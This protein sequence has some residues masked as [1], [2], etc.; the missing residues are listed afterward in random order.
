MEHKEFAGTGFGGA[1]YIT[2]VMTEPGAGDGV[3]VGALVKRTST[4]LDFVRVADTTPT[5]FGV[6]VASKN[7]GG[8]NYECVILVVGVYSGTAFE[9]DTD[10]SNWVATTR[11]KSGVLQSP[12]YFV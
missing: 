1:I 6:V 10:T 8:G 5:L 2:T 12:I 4:G 11:H 9:Y 3:P 7:L